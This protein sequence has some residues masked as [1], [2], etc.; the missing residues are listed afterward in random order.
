MYLLR[1]DTSNWLWNVSSHITA[2]LMSLARRID[3]REATNQLLVVDTCRWIDNLSRVHR[4]VWIR[5][6]EEDGGSEERS[7]WCLYYI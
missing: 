7:S 4:R 1:S 5:I 2:I 6:N 3:R